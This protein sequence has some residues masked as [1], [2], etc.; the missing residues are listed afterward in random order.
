MV[1]NLKLEENQNSPTPVAIFQLHIRLSNIKFCGLRR[2]TGLYL[3]SETFLG[4]G[5][6]LGQK[7]IFA[8]FFF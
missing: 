3:D 7:F 5:S 1:E 6:S 8:F 2:S 4:Y